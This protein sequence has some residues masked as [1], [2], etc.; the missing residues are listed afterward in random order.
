MA[1]VWQDG[2]T[3]MIRI[4]F[5]RFMAHCYA[6]Q[7]S[8]LRAELAERKCVVTGCG[9]YDGGE[10]RRL[11]AELA[12]SRAVV[13]DICAEWHEDCEPCC[14]SF[15]HAENCRAV[16]IAAAKR[17]LNEEVVGLRAECDALLD[18]LRKAYDAMREPT[19]EWHDIKCNSVLPKIRVAIDAALKDGK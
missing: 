14:D 17:A 12:N 13:K 11:Q 6:R 10:M 9:M 3:A 8:G 1:A 4:L 7:E 19:G 15:G 2:G 16:S 5:L 18:L